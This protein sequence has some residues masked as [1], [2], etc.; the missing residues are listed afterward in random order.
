[1]RKVVVSG[2]NGFIG[3]SLIRKLTAAG[4][5]VHAL[6][7]DNH[8]RLG[9]MLPPD[10]I[11]VLK[12][13]VGSAVEIVTRVQPDT[14][15]HLAAVYAEPISAPSVLS[16]ID[17]NLTLGA[18]LLF[19]ATKCATPPI[20]INTGTY[21]QFD[22]NSAYSPNTVYAA[23]KQAFQDILHFYRSRQQLASVTLI[24]YDTFGEGDTRPK[25]WHRLTSAEPGA[26]FA[27]SPGD[28]TIHLVHIDD[29]VSAFLRAAELLHD[30]QPLDAVYS[31]CSSTPATLRDLVEELNATGNLGLNLQWG[32][33]P[34]WEG[35]VAQPWVG[36]QLPGWSAQTEVLAALLRMAHQTSEEAQR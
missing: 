34:Y 27:L 31:V 32:K 15:F 28:Q 9:A 23:T 25:L 2:G 14:I 22:E 8:Q 12:E 24:L 3:S 36:E 30:R 13:G 18:C 21:W 10:C 29:T 6:V 20:F 5:E 33:L 17:G 1:M 35:Q 19:A 11:H 26:S 4:V 7:N 16:M